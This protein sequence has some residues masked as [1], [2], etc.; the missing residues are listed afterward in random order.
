MTWLFQREHAPAFCYQPI[1]TAE[2][3]NEI[4]EYGKSLTSVRASVINAGETMEDTNVRSCLVRSITPDDIKYQWIF[5]KLQRFVEQSNY[6]YFNYD[7]HGIVEALQLLEYNAPA[8]KYNMHVDNIKHQLVRKLSVTVNLSHHND[9]EG[10]EL[11]LHTSEI[12]LVPPKTIGTAIMFPS[13]SPHSVTTVTSGTR[14]SLVA[15]VAGPPLR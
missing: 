10:G 1:F 2:E 4:I 11:Q 7:L 15:W 5:H 12:P 6:E 8:G 13:H 3:C 14:F 9:Y